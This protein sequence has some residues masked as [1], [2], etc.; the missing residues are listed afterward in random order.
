MRWL[1]GFVQWGPLATGIPSSPTLHSLSKI[2]P[3]SIFISA[4]AGALQSLLAFYF[5]RN[6]FIKF[7]S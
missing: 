4:S 3:L 1:D 2:F 7:I 5:N 6:E